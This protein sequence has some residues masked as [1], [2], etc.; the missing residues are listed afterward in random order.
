MVSVKIN[1]IDADEL[2]CPKNGI[3]YTIFVY[4]TNDTN[5]GFTLD[6]MLDDPLF[7]EAAM[8]RCGKPST[9]GERIYWRNGASLSLHQIFSMIQSGANEGVS[10]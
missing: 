8:S 4:L 5:I 2:F 1:R 7:Y 9:D 10:P 6:S 3:G